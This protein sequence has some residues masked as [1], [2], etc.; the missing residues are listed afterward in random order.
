M[1]GPAAASA[2]ARV[3][4]PGAARAADPARHGLTL[5]AKGALAFVVLALYVVLV[6]WFVNVERHKLLLMVDELEQ[7]HRT[8]EQLVQMNMSL[9]R[10]MLTVNENFAEPDLYSVVAPVIMELEAV[11]AASNAL[12]GPN[13]RVVILANALHAF[14]ND[15]A[16]Q[17]SR[18]VLALARGT[19]QELAGE[20]AQVT[21][22]E[23]VRKLELL[24]DYRYTYDRV[25]LESMG[26]SL[27]GMIV[28]GAVTA[29]FFS[30]LA[31]DIRKL[32]GRARAIVRGYR[33]KPLDVTRSDEVGSLMRAVN[34]MQ[35]DLREGEKQLEVGRQ[36]H[37]HREKMAA[38]GSLA[39]QLA[40]EINNPISAIAGIAQSIAE[41]R[42]SHQCPNL[43][44]A[45][46]P[47]LI[48]EQ[49][50]RISSI[51]R[52]ISDF[53][54]PRSVESELLDLNSLVRSTCNF[55]RYDRRF[56]GIELETELD[57]ELP[58]VHAV[59]DHLTQV[60][61]NLLI[62]AADAMEGA[63]L[64]GRPR[65]TVSTR[66]ARDRVLLRV[67]DNGKGMDAE[68]AR[69]AFDEY[70]TTKPLGKGT[71]LG[72]AVCRSLVEQG[73]GTITLSSLPG[74]GTTVDVRLPLD[75][76]LQAG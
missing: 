14:A 65:I 63:A 62:N 59:G 42:E 67:A 46:Q 38:V 35:A 55:V 26:L 16:R 5:R 64:A 51:T 61:M 58:A 10:T 33:G 71:G 34:K 29:L 21:R 41:S 17:P 53:S 31:W 6:G 32:E 3:S 70:Y 50:K 76:P 69:R 49:A 60:L 27:L 57:P 20:V 48:L 23:R 22:R 72:L 28:F 25:T 15:L 56:R 75:A 9:A 39:A 2:P 74:E 68:T 30:R 47:E 11:R 37:F 24:D 18:G 8:E 36:Q 7:V 13:P 52:Q 40:H 12:Q 43:G 45:C 1:N 4:A 54:V 44:V 73:R 19:L 66:L